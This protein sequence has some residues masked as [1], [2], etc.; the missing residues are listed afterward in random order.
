MT[1]DQAPPQGHKPIA[2]FDAGIGSYSAVATIR[3]RF[4]QQDIIYFADRAS[5]PYGAKSLAETA[6][7]H[8]PDP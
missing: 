4:P 2:V 5:F 8:Q 7:H 1:P 6:G 3:N